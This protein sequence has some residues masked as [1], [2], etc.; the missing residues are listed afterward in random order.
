MDFSGRSR[1]AECERL[2]K[3][4]NP[5]LVAYECSQKQILNKTELSRTK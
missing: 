1:I 3:K 5:A 4:L 2:K